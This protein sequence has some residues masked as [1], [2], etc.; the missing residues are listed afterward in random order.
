[1]ASVLVVPLAPRDVPHAERLAGRLGLAVAPVGMAPPSRT[2]A[3]GPTLRLEVSERRL[4]LRSEEGAAVRAA[5]EVLERPPRRGPDPFLRAVGR[6][7]EQGY[8]LDATAGLGRDGFLLAAHGYRVELVERVPV[9]AALLEDVLGRAAAGALGPVAQATA[10]RIRF[11]PGDATPHLAALA[12]RRD[13]RPEVVTVDPMYPWGGKTALPNK[14][15]AL[16]RQLV[17]ADDD[18]ADVLTAARLAATRRVVVKR[19]LRA[20]ALPG[21]PPSGSIVGSTTRWDLYAGTPER[22]R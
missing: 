17:G 5:Q 7:A 22:G 9:V 18:A 6:V 15:M 2:D 16:F 10:A 14:G 8:V 3:R 4:Q 21:P 19:P 20:D 1:M 12:R 13:G 11:I